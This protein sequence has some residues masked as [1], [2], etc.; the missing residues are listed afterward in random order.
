[1]WGVSDLRLI[2]LCLL[3]HNE[4]IEKE[5][6]AP[7]ACVVGANFRRLKGPESEGDLQP[8]SGF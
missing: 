1:M 2:V 4:T 5:A 3:P 7:G 8:S 6:D